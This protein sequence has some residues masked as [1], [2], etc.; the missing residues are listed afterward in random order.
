LIGSDGRR[1][2][3]VISEGREWRGW[4]SFAIEMRKVV[5]FFGL[6]F[7]KGSSFLLSCQP[8]GGSQLTTVGGPS[9][10]STGKEM[11]KGDGKRTFAEVVGRVGQLHG[12]H[13]A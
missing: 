13:S 3:I 8:I 4:S 6:T 7:G 5:S 9:S 11:T 2:F 12:C 10:I 1:G